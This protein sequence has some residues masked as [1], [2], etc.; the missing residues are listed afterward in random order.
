[1][2]SLD[3]I[4][5]FGESFGQ[6]LG[7]GLSKMLDSQQTGE[8]FG[9]FISKTIQSTIESLDFTK[10]VQEINRSSAAA[11]NQLDFKAAAG[12]IGREIGRVIYA[13]GNPATQAFGAL[14][15]NLAR[16]VTWNIV[17]HFAAGIATLTGTPLLAYFLY[18]K[19]LHNIGRPQLIKEERKIALAE[20]LQD[21]IFRTV[22]GGMEALRSGAK[23]GGIVGMTTF[24]S[25]IPI[26]LSA[27]LSRNKF[28]LS[29]IFGGKYFIR[30]L[31]LTAGSA[32][33]AST[34]SVV[35]QTYQSIK[36]LRDQSSKP[37]P[38]FNAKLTAQI[39]DITDSTYNL[40]KNKGYFQNL[41]L[42]GVGGTGKTM[43]AKKI[44]EDSGLNYVMMS[45]GDLPQYISR[46]EHVTELNKLFKSIKKPS[47]QTILFIDEI[48]ALC[49][50]R[51]E[52]TEPAR[53][54]LTSAFLNL[55]GDASNQFMLIGATNKKELLD[56]AFLTRMD[57]R[58]EIKPPAAEERKKILKQNIRQSFTSSEQEQWFNDAILDEMV[59]KTDGLTGRDLFKMINALYSKM[60]CSANR[61]LSPDAIQTM[62]NNFIEQRQPEA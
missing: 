13:S 46:G 54:D 15:G 6:G 55:T 4:K 11:T 61:T 34:S 62:I 7:A 24:G 38:V 52:Q 44:A 21:T 45:G 49:P 43:I 27:A 10:I 41:L 47:T 19:A 2:I 28:L 58:L 37:G 9:K 18:R 57:W 25:Y 51:N 33:L 8:N 31:A 29:L 5:Q 42:Y 26:A 60:M 53:F 35:T 59:L 17:P 12:N 50:E 56:E 48:E 1:M 39:K 14:A 16:N 36:Q 30:A 3:R 20:R 32:I 23:W 40:K 22:G